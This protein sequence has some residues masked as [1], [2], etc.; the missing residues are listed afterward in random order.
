VRQ[1][2]SAIPQRNR[3][4]I[5]ES[6]G[7]AISCHKQGQLSEAERHYEAVLEADARHFGA[8]HGLGL[9]R[10]QQGRFADAIPLLRRAIK[11]DRDAAEAHHHLGVAL[12]GLGRP[13][14]AL[15]RFEK[16]LSLKPDLAEAHDSFGHALQLLGRA[17]KAIAHHKEALKINPNYV[18]AHNNLGLALKK[19]ERPEQAIQQYDKALAL[20]PDYPEAHNNLGQALAALGRHQAAVAE[21]E[22]ALALRPDYAEAHVNLGELLLVTGRSEEAIKHCEKAAALRPN[23]PNVQNSLGDALRVLGRSEEAIQAFEMALSLAPRKSSTYWNLARSRPFTAADPHFVAM[24]K[25]G[26]EIQSLEVNDQIG[27]H[28]A[29]AKAFADLGEA[30]QSAEH[31]VQGNSLKRR[32]ITYDEAETLGRL[33]RIRAVFSKDLMRAKRAGGFPSPR[34]IFILGMPRS[35]TTLVEQI[36]ASHPQVFGAGELNEMNDLARSIGGANGSEFPEAVAALSDQQMHDLGER[37]LHALDR[38]APPRERVTDKLP[39]NFAYMGLIHLALPGARIIHTCRDP[40]DTALSCFSILFGEGQLEFTYELGELGRYVRAYLRLMEHWRDVLPE[41]VM[42]EIQYED[43]VGNL[44]KNARRIVAHCGLGW[45]EACLAFHKTKRAVRTASVTQVR[46]P[47]YRTSVGRW[48]PY[49]Q[50]LQPFIRALEE[51]LPVAPGPIE[52]DA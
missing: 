9:V 15:E 25:L 28:F 48:Q 31:L 5:F 32:Q 6:L 3:R 44:E 45:D 23:H 19:L 33:D 21:Y 24:K 1:R 27:L 11:I 40:R 7:D 4:P 42:L 51:P 13:E 41:G 10:L 43:L 49:E 46:Q 20:R 12:T 22:T 39:A 8:V 38:Y 26:R 50:L 30:Q 47:I 14:E 16:A 17:E 2:T 18:E 29:L 34:P 35:G 37:Y 52:T 36:L